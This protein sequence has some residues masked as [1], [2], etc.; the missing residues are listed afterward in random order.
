MRTSFTL[1]P[2]PNRGEFY[3][4]AG[5]PSPTN[6]VAPRNESLTAVGGAR[7]DAEEKTRNSEGIREGSGWYGI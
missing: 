6:I 3:R 7:P 2:L 1:P 4:H 5:T